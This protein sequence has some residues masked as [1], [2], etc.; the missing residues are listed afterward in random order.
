M[1]P[2]HPLTIAADRLRGYLR[3]VTTRTEALTAAWRLQ[4]ADSR[5]QA[6]KA[7]TDEWHVLQAAEERQR[8]W[9]AWPYWDV[10]HG[11]HRWCGACAAVEDG[12]AV[13]CPA[14]PGGE[15]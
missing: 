9:D 2:T 7:A 13:S 10:R 15:R 12:E 4:R 5:E 14:H 11:R 8:A 3:A 6:V 1:T